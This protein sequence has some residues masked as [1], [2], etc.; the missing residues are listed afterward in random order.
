MAKHRTVLWHQQAQWWSS[1]GPC[2]IDD[3]DRHMKG[4]RQFGVTTQERPNIDFIEKAT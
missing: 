4:W 2:K 1:F 3:Q